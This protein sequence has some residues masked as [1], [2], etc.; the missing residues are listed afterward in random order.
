MIS[1]D[2]HTAEE[3]GLRI[4]AE[5]IEPSI[6]R[7]RDVTVSIPGMHGAYYFGSDFEPR[8]FNIPISQTEQ[9]L[10]GDSYVLLKRLKKL[11]F[12]E[13]GR[14][15][16]VKLIILTQPD[17]YY[18][19]RFQ[20]SMSLQELFRY[21]RFELPFVA[22]DPHAYAT[23]K[24][25]E[26]TWGS[27]EVTFQNTMYTYGHVGQG[28]ERITATKT[29]N[30][31]VDGLLIAPKIS[32]TGT[33][34]NVRIALRGVGMVIPSFSGTVVIDSSK[35]EVTYNGNDA[36]SMVRG[37]FLFFQDGNNPLAI[38]GTAMNFDLYVDLRNKYM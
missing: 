34:T 32:I 21:K 25:D 17:I 31:P 15:K 3:L 30:Y 16:E 6:P 2:G 5:F 37:E 18:N 36:L 13:T 8:E 12:D 38:T 9:E 26:V 1:L 19:V 7:T 20:G 22:Y 23:S 33:G 24:Q 27:T 35:Y 11:L 10:R 14:P 28:K 4:H 29:I